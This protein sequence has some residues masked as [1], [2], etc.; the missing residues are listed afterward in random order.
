MLHVSKQ[1]TGKIRGLQTESPINWTTLRSSISCFILGDSAFSFWE[2]FPQRN[3]IS[4]IRILLLVNDV[5]EAFSL[6]NLILHLVVLRDERFISAKLDS[7]YIFVSPKNVKVNGDH[8]SYQPDLY[9]DWGFPQGY[10]IKNS[11]CKLSKW[12]VSSKKITS[13]CLF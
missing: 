6:L 5:T 4:N 7:L 11:R 10:S 13:F 8:V 3:T 12:F 1:R 2:T 9:G